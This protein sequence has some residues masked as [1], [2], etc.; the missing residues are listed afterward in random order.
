MQ[1]FVDN[2]IS[3]CLAAGFRPGLRALVEVAQTGALDVVVAADWDRYTRS[4]LD[5][6]RLLDWAE[7]QGVLLEVAR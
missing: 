6:S 7:E 5:L 1:V 3:G 2:G 4:P